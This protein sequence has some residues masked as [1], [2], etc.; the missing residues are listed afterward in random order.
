MEYLRTELEKFAEKYIGDV[1]MKEDFDDKVSLVR[2]LQMYGG[3]LEEIPRFIRENDI[4]LKKIFGE[5]NVS[6]DLWGLTFTLDDSTLL[7]ELID[8]LNEST[9]KY[10][11]A[12]IVPT[13]VYKNF[14][15]FE[16]HTYDGNKHKI[17]RKNH[18]G[19][20]D[21]FIRTESEFLQTYF[22]YIFSKETESLIDYY[23]SLHCSDG[24]K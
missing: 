24:L 22:Y 13:P 16:K 17:R 7:D 4:S 3:I 5:D 11:E 14:I 10:L 1:L 2:H 6:V 23:E 8:I 19:M 18:M 20:N 12:P 9:P 15:N 21:G